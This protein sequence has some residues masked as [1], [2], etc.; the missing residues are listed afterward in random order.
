M[1]LEQLHE[2]PLSKHKSWHFLW[3]CNFSWYCIWRKAYCNP[4]YGAM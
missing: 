2:S 1:S 3:D 4:E